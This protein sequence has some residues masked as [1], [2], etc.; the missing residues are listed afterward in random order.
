MP[1]DRGNHPPLST[2]KDYRITDY[3]ELLPLKGSPRSTL[4]GHDCS[5]IAG[6]INLPF[7]TDYH[8]CTYYFLWHVAI[9]GGFSLL[10]SM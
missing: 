8:R 6:S 4:F 10:S 2:K 3:K 7:P 1:T 5:R 9:T